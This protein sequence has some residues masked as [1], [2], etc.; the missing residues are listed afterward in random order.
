MRNT[1]F[2]WQ[3]ELLRTRDG[4]HTVEK[5]VQ[6]LIFIDTESEAKKEA[7]AFLMIK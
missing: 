6:R 2:L 4:K 3:V 7:E 1:A 5:I